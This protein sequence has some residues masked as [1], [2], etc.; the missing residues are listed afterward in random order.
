MS[1]DSIL[2]N[3]S[4]KHMILNNSVREFQG[5][6]TGFGDN[7][8]I[9]T[10]APFE[11]NSAIRSDLA[12]TSDITKKDKTKEDEKEIF[13]D[14]MSR[15]ITS[16]ILNSTLGTFYV[17]DMLLK[18][19]DLD[20]SVNRYTA[21][22][23]SPFELTTA[24]S[25][26]F[27]VLLEDSIDEGRLPNG[28]RETLLK[29][30]DC[31]KQSFVTDFPIKKDINEIANMSDM[32]R[33]STRPLVTSETPT[34]Y[35]VEEAQTVENVVRVK[36]K[37]S[38]DGDIPILDPS[39]R[40]PVNEREKTVVKTRKVIKPAVKGKKIT[41]YSE[42]KLDP[43]TVNLS[44]R[45]PKPEKTN[46]V[47]IVL[48]N[49][50]YSMQTRNQSYL[51][52]FFNAI[53]Q[54]DMSLSSPFIELTF[55]N[56]I[57]QPNQGNR[58][59][60]RLNQVAY[61]RFD[62]N[63]NLMKMSKFTLKP[64]FNNSG[65]VISN[66]AYGD[67][68]PDE[69]AA[70]VHADGDPVEVSFQNIF[71][72]PQTLNNADI[73]NVESLFGGR[74]DDNGEFLYDSA[75]TTLDPFAPMMSLTGFNVTISE[76]G[77]YAVSSRRASMKLVLHDRS[78]LADITP[79]VTPGS[80]QKTSVKVTYGWTHPLANP[81]SRNE[82][83]NVIANFIDSM[84]ETAFYRLSSSNLRLEGSKVDINVEMDFMGGKEM[85]NIPCY[86]GTK[87]E[88]KSIK[89]TFK[90]ALKYIT[91][92]FKEE[93]KVHKN[94][95]IVERS[96]D[97]YDE[98]VNAKD[99]QDLIELL[100]KAGN[101]NKVDNGM[102]EQIFKQMLILIN[103]FTKEEIS[104]NSMEEILTKIKEKDFSQERIGVQARNSRLSQE[105]FWNRLEAVTNKTV[106]RRV[107]EEKTVSGSQESFTQTVTETR[108]QDA[109]GSE[110]FKSVNWS[111]QY[112]TPDY[113]T[114][115]GVMNY[116][117]E[118]KYK[119]NFDHNFISYLGLEEKENLGESQELFPKGFVSL[120]KLVQNL[121]GLPMTTKNLYNEVQVVY[122]PVNTEAAG[123]RI[124]TT[125]S[126][127]ISVD[128]LYNVLDSYVKE[129]N[130][131]TPDFIFKVFAKIL[132]NRNAVCY[133]LFQ[134]NKRTEDELVEKYG[135]TRDKETGEITLNEEGQKAAH[136]EFM[137]LY[138]DK[139]KTIPTLA[140]IMAPPDP[141]SGAS[142]SET[143]STTTT[144]GSGTITS[145]AAEELKEE[146]E[147]DARKLKQPM[148]ENFVDSYRQTGIK[149]K[150]ESFYKADGI[151]APADLSSFKMINLKMDVE[152]CQVL[153]GE[154]GQKENV[155]KLNSL[156]D[157]NQP[158][159][160]NAKIL[161]LHIYDAHS[162]PQNGLSF[163][164]EKVS[165]GANYFRIQG[166]LSPEDNRKLESKNEELN[167]IT[168]SK[169]HG[170]AL[171]ESKSGRMILNMPPWLLKKY[172]KREY[173]SITYGAVNSVVKSINLS[174]TTENEIAYGKAVQ[175]WQD[176]EEGVYSKY[177]VQQQMDLNII[178]ST[179]DMQ[180]LGCPFLKVCGH[181][182]VDTG[183]NTDM[184]NV[185]SIVSFDHSIT[186]GNFTTNVRLALP[187]AAS[188]SNLR[189]AL[190]DS[191]AALSEDEDLKKQLTEE[192]KKIEKG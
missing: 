149:E 99:H 32:V 6:L 20:E 114:K 188:T 171:V 68:K 137:E 148:F 97:S 181:I 66:T 8:F 29:H 45:E 23:L 51:S 95:S 64:A 134:E 47:A 76:G 13:E 43:N 190:A 83:E 58:E 144:S 132:Q 31:W 162:S 123:A 35:I 154:N 167:G 56:I 139:D 16:S 192:I 59:D 161:R 34:T 175:S 117:Y 53:S 156:S 44:F 125:A 166:A 185:Y 39:S 37:I 19:S 147:F 41:K 183:T 67:L 133:G 101:T 93:G 24:Y 126:I 122:Y 87:E 3:P 107:K 38:T 10:F 102:K 172:L 1:L 50:K 17:K 81:H 157:I 105:L 191:L 184:D 103:L 124:H 15:S 86:S 63:D 168:Y 27:R 119:N 136:S 104:N 163:I 128:N 106:S 178:P 90:S 48:K 158:Y 4:L 116:K 153:H 5:Y 131:M 130:F 129:G 79:F 65:E 69:N 151:P 70:H 26:N 169:K 187:F 138:A 57:P 11:V 7:N 14:E 173:P 46:L 52:V 88:I 115:T 110:L 150:L 77:Y 9:D 159:V 113:F 98:L 60:N 61:M 182:Y 152:T 42:L 155:L 186:Q 121:V 21:E 33:E 75:K 135:Y 71:Q 84:R 141:P 91:E 18:G 180:M 118:E 176:Q 85:R 112:I 62:S 72:S 12:R 28:M 120:G 165:R 100:K 2:E 82:R 94:L 146:P 174:S 170:R 30:G 36:K 89:D 109:G 179:I 111:E 40:Q 54:I 96:I 49:P 25:K 143:P 164:S 127:P 22:K 74:L 177:I 73:N 78:R 189:F 140:E 92:D 55:F 145:E 108:L 142:E 160:G 80:L